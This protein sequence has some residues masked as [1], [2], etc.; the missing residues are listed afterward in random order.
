[1]CVMNSAPFG[2]LK[3]I[4]K[5]GVL[6]EGSM[7]SEMGKYNKQKSWNRLVIWNV[8]CVADRLEE[9]SADGRILLK[10]IFKNR[11]KPSSVGSEQR[12]L[13]GSC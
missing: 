11:C 4:S 10:Y 7:R 2:A 1:M 13:V 5:S 8:A 3:G 12:Q 6:I 9:L